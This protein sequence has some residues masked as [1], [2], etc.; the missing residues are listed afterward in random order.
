[1]RTQ[2]Y[3]LSCVKEQLLDFKVEH[4]YTKRTYR[5][6]TKRALVKFD[7]PA[8][9]GK[10]IQHQCHACGRSLTVRIMSIAEMR[11]RLL[12][13]AIGATV[14]GAGMLIWGVLAFP[15]W[16]AYILLLFGCV[17][18]F[19]GIPQFFSLDTQGWLYFSYTDN[20]RGR[21]GNVRLVDQDL[22]G[23][24]LAHGVHAI[25]NPKALR[26]TDG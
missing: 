18:F 24:E 19:G 9:E 17:H 13:V 15:R 25:R 10:T 22:F 7:V 3:Q 4:P 26:P 1:M 6:E 23:H 16:Y 21:S 8:E 11:Q 2:V 12:L 5:V 20:K 14:S